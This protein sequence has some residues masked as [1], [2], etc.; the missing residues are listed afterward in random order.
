VGEAN[1]V[2][3][4]G[5]VM[6]AGINLKSIL[7]ASIILMSCSVMANATGWPQ[8]DIDQAIQVVAAREK[9]YIEECVTSSGTKIAYDVAQRD[10]NGDG[11]NELIVDSYPA[12]LG[13][14]VTGCYGRVGKNMY[15]MSKAN[16]NWEAL[17]IG[18]DTHDFVFHP[19][20]SGQ[21]PDVELTGPGFCFPIQ[22]YHMGEYKLWKVCDGNRQLFADAAP[23]IEDKSSVVPHEYGESNTTEN[24]AQPVAIASNEAANLVD[25]RSL[26]DH[27]GSDVRIAPSSGTIIYE[28]PK[29]GIA[30]TVKSGMLLFKADTPWDPYDD[31]A[32]VKGTAYVFKKGCEPAPYQVSGH[33][34]GWHTLVLKGA[35]PVREKNGCRVIG[36]KM[37]SNAT[38]KFV[39]LGD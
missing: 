27:N 4:A 29:K 5:L 25:M 22:R 34:Q 20:Q 30:G 2:V 24:V 31:N 36:Y 6:S 35:A 26:F 10:V 21:M 11:V 7:T 38:L 9:D 14:G 17:V 28:S 37:N 1:K 19:R 13:S 16:G 33:Q 23:W 12:E 32:P 3:G 8:A 15:L 18:D 39:S